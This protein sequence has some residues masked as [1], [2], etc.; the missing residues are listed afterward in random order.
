MLK[1]ENEEQFETETTLKQIF[2]EWAESS[3]S[4]GFPNIFRTK[5]IAIK[6]MWLIFLIV[7]SG[8]CGYMVMKSILD[9]LSFDVI[10]KIRIQNE[11]PMEFP[12]ITI[13]NLNPFYKKQIHVYMQEVLGYNFSD[14]DE[15]N[16]TDFDNGIYL[17]SN[18]FKEPSFSQ[19]KLKETGPSIDQM[20]IYCS[21]MSLECTKDD[22]EW[23]FMPDYGNCYRFNSGKNSTSDQV[24]IKEIYSPGVWTSVIRR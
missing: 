4:H 19:E 24:P 16:I 7:S 12:T 18:L 9:Y 22:F 5:I 8:L 21:F 20:L 13:C 17:I 23:Y 6:I 15:L 11:V 10:T 1:K 3:T 2:L 14:F